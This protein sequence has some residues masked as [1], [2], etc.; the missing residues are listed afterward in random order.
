MGAA[1]GMNVIGCIEHPRTP[2]LEEKLA[3]RGIRLAEFDEVI[4]QSDF[5]SIH[6]PKKESTLNLFNA[7]VFSRVKKG[8]YLINL[9]RGGVVNEKDLYDELTKGG[10]LRGAALDV[11]ENEGEGNISPFAA[12]PNVVL[13]PH[14]GAQTIDSQKE[15]G[16]RVEEI[17]ED[18]IAQKVPVEAAVAEVE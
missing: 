11:H 4:T 1:W 3:K 12:F 7:D 8:A 17:I 16:D 6:C 13:T 5:I 10:R 18:Y 9:A 14:M 2:E 15:I